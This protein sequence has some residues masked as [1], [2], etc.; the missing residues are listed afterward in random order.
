MS[1]IPKVL[2]Q[3]SRKT[4]PEYVIQMIKAKIQPEW[5]YC[6]YTDADVLQ[7]F[8]DYPDEEFPELE[9]R[10]YSFR[11]GEHRADLFRYYYLYKCGGVY[12]DTDA[13]V[14]TNIENIVKNYEFFSV[15]STYF[16]KS[17]F[18][19][20]IGCVPGHSI[21]YKALKNIYYI[22]THNLETD[23]HILCKNMYV[24]YKNQYI[25]YHIE[26][27]PDK[28]T[29]YKEK[30]GNKTEAHIVDENDNIVLI[31]YHIDK[32]IPDQTK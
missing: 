6:H 16:P 18:Q 17:I 12:M 27:K 32:I 3:T 15:D 4:P 1:I 9:K 29:L 28:I 2:V 14:L 5:I 22:D 23:F 13:M 21:I 8:Q 20:F 7:F 24:Y 25:K 30:Y 26:G 31:H 11:Y 10:F 19:G